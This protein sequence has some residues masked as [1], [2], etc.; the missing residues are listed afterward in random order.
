MSKSA[1]NGSCCCPGA[2]ARH[3]RKKIR[4]PSLIPMLPPI[5]RPAC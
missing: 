3:L 1:R 5:L 2:A 4:S